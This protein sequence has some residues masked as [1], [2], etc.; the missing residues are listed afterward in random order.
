MNHTKA[1]FCAV[2]FASLCACGADPGPKAAVDPAPSTS[3]PAVKAPAA[4]DPVTKMARAVGSGKPGAAVDIRYE[5]LQKPVVGTPLTLEIALLPAAGVD[6]MEATISGMD[7]LT[8]SGDLS[9]SFANVQVGEAY[10]HTVTVLPERS[11]VYYVTVSVS[12]QMR[13]QTLGRSF[14]VPLVVG[15]L[16]ARQKTAPAKEASGEAIRSLPAQEST[17]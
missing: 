4:Q 12:T 3:K 17:D 8:V 13:G 14:S 15:D 2:L 5:F 1:I 10:K 11:G 6:A 9:A 7:G 16:P